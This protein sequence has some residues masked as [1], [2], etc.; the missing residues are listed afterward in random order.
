MLAG[1]VGVVALTMGLLSAVFVDGGG[2]DLI[3]LAPLAA[4]FSMGPVLAMVAF[5]PLSRRGLVLAGVLFSAA[6]VLMWASYVTSDSSTSALVFIF[7]W[8]VGIP[9]AAM[10]AI[11]LG[12]RARS[13]AERAGRAA[14]AP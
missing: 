10:A 11:V 5:V 14:Q 2:A 13:T 9:V 12:I 4:V 7:G 3:L 1:I 8:F 6:L